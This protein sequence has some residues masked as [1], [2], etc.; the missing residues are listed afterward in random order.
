MKDAKSRNVTIIEGDSTDDVSKLTQHLK[1]FDVIISTID[2]ASQLA[3]RNLVEAA[4]AAGVKR[5]VPCGFITI[6]PPGGIMML[7]DAKEEIHNL[8]FQLH[9][10]YTIID[11]G[12]WHVL[13]FPPLPSGKVDYAAF[14]S[15]NTTIYGDGT[16][17]NLLTHLPDIGTYV[18]KIVKDPRTLN[19]RVVT[20]SDELSQNQIFEM[21]EEV[22]GEKLERHYV[23]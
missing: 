20:W 21:M 1:G 9:L 4:A 8:I 12:F 15:S 18:A 22:S 13:S 7:R 14:V 23:S 6:S 16:A 3:Q 2:A 11:V 5:F 10:P 19:K 17:P